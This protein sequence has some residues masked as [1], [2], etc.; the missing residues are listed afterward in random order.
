MRFTLTIT[1]NCISNIISIAIILNFIFDRYHCYKIRIVV[2]PLANECRRGRYY[3][4]TYRQERVTMRKILLHGSVGHFTSGSFQ[5]RSSP[6]HAVDVISRTFR[7]RRHRRT[8]CRRYRGRAA[9]C[10]RPLSFATRFPLAR[11]HTII[12]SR[13][14]TSSRSPTS[15]PNLSMAF[16]G[17]RSP[18]RYKKC[19]M[20]RVVI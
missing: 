10:R 1:Q 14:A 8:P 9:E 12:I 4:A 5:Y 17:S 16:L 3:F 18:R 19:R 13:H 2:V 11:R 15:T 6:V 20:P 7:W